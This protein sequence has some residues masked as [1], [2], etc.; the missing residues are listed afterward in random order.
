MYGKWDFK[1]KVVS[2]KSEEGLGGK[3][4]LRGRGWVV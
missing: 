2:T 1:R 3:G 4:G